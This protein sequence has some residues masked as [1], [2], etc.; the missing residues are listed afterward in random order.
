VIAA[1]I[2]VA[3]LLLDGLYHAIGVILPLQ[4]ICTFTLSGPATPL[5]V[6]MLHSPQRHFFFCIS[7]SSGTE[8]D[9]SDNWASVNPPSV[10]QVYASSRSSAGHTL[11]SG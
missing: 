10:L 7:A 1:V 3:T 6:L 5:S 8:A 11:A 2:F 9:P 4:A